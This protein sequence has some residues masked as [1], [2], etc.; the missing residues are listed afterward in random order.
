MINLYES[1]AQIN[2]INIKN[3]RAKFKTIGSVM[4][5]RVVKIKFHVI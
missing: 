4:E 3:L 5:F 2:T 1:N